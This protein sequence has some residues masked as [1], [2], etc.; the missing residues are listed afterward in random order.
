[1]WLGAVSQGGLWPGMASHGMGCKQ[2]PAHS[3]ECAVGCDQQHTAL[4]GRFSLRTRYKYRAS[5]L[6]A[7]SPTLRPRAT[8]PV[9]NRLWPQGHAEGTRDEYHSSSTCTRSSTGR[10]RPDGRRARSFAPGACIRGSCTDAGTIP[11]GC[12]RASRRYCSRSIPLAIHRRRKRASRRRN[13]PS[14][15]STGTRRRP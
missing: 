5:H 1:M 2:L 12:P 14:T 15:C 4:R 6:S 3:R 7:I 9:V 11:S 10:R 13:Q 8:C